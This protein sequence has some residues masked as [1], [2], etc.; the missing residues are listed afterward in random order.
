MSPWG[1]FYIQII[2]HT[3]SAFCIRFSII[4]LSA[5][6]V[7]NIILKMQKKNN[8]HSSLCNFANSSRGMWSLNKS[9]HVGMVV[10]TYNPHS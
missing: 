5:Y 10:P 2:F 6:N 4:L 3:S 1:I 8:L 9:L 7:W